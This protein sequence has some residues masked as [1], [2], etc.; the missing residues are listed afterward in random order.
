MMQNTLTDCLDEKIAHLKPGFD[1][2]KDWTNSGAHRRMLNKSVDNNPSNFFYKYLGYN[3]EK[4]WI[5]NQERNN[6]LGN[7]EDK[8]FRFYLEPMD[9]TRSNF[10]TLASQPG[11][12]PM[13]INGRFIEADNWDSE[14]E[15]IR[16]RNR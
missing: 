12:G 9:E 2:M 15:Y 14:P 11:N 10:H 16:Q 4:S 8:K 7:W 1:F 13:N 5:M 3:P 6:N